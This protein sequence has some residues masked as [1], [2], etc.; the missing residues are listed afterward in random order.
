M[1]MCWSRVI[2]CD[3]WDNTTL[4]GRLAAV[5]NMGYPRVPNQTSSI[6]QVVVVVVR[7]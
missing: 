4:Y 2:I 7:G 3:L 5:A 6:F 1:L